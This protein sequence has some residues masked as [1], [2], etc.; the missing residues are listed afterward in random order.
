MNIAQHVERSARH[1]RSRPA[2]I[3][4]DRTV[5]YGELEA[6]ASRTAHGLQS[7]GVAAEDR[8]AILLPNIPEFP[9]VYLATAKTGAV[10]VSLNVMLVP[11]ELRYVLA[12]SG[13]KVLF[14]TAAQW[15]QVQPVVG[16]LPGLEHIVLCEGTIAGTRTLAEL[17]A[18][19]PDAFKPVDLDRSAPAAILYT[20]GT[21]GKQKGATLSHGNVISNILATQHL[22]RID[23]DDRVALFLPLFHCFGQNFIMN[24]GF[25]AGACLVM[26]RRFDGDAVLASVEKLGVTV[27]SAVPTIYIN[28]LTA[29]VPKARLASVRLFFSAAAPLPKEVAD[30]WRDVYGK[31]IYQGYGLTETSPLACFNHEFEHRL[32]SVG[33][34]IENVEMKVLDPEDREAPPNTWGEIAIRGPNVM[35]GYWNRPEETAQALRGGWFHTGDVGYVDAD[36]YFFLVDRLKDMVNS[37]GFKIWPREV[38]EALYRHPAVQECAVLGAPD[39]VM[40]EV[41][42]AFVVLQPD[43]RA[44]AEEIETFCREHVSAYKVPRKVLVVPELPKSPTGKLLKRVLREWLA[45]DRRLS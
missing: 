29:E 44:R 20:S 23:R 38:E 30:R 22:L 33:T 16:S 34:P 2:L 27:F 41:V 21:T 4:G 9:V 5:T 1:F 45:R 17:G 40:G 24:A 25:S 39:P 31:P 15:P 3:S 14:T 11:D 18:G 13:A 35:I 36:G 43:A 10:A 6:A 26:H 37:A 8:V 19:R 42:V 12:D 32:G 7:L 28:L